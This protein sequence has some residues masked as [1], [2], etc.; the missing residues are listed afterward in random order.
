MTSHPDQYKSFQ[1]IERLLASRSVIIREDGKARCDS[2][3]KNGCSKNTQAFCC[4]PRKGVLWNFK[5]SLVQSIMNYERSSDHIEVE[6]I[7]SNM[8]LE[9]RDTRRI[10]DEDHLLDCATPRMCGAPDGC[11]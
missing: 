10:A 11:Q 1:L 7:P 3:K 9:S 5:A 8:T 4:N 2:Y 6:Q